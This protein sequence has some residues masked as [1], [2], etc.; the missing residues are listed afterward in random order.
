[1]AEADPMMHSEVDNQ[2]QQVHTC[3]LQFQTMVGLNQ[4]QTCQATE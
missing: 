4:I 1:M 2:S 3:S